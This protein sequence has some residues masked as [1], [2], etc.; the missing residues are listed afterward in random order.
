MR[1][2]RGSW[3]YRTTRSLAG[4]L[5]AGLLRALA[6]T[7]R[8]EIEGPNPFAEP[9][10][11][12]DDEPLVLVAWHRNLFVAMGIFRD[13]GILIPVSKSRDG[14]W[15][16]AVLGRLGFGESPR[17]SSS[18]GASTL[19]RN[20]IRSTRAGHRVGMLPDG[21]RGPAGVAQ[22]G[23]VALARITGARLCTAGSSASSCW[24]FGSWDR[25]I[26]P[27]PFARVRCR[28]GRRLHVPKGSDGEAL[29]AHLAELQAELHRLD[30]GLDAEWHP[31]VG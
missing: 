4:L 29:A 21:P 12:Q 17:G 13:L 23:V 6:L 7:W 3:L 26:L 11:G 18:D 9:G 15:V 16:E 25:P 1:L 20:L 14:D 28:F 31:P 2:Q 10:S 8:V 5:V 30:D 27:R 19:L 22:P 24:R